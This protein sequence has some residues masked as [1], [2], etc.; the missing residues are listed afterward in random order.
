MPSC[1]GWTGTFPS[2]DEQDAEI[3]TKNLQIVVEPGVI[4]ADL[5]EELKNIIFFPPDPS[6][7]VESTLG[8]N[9][10]ENAGYT[11][12]V[13]YGVMTIISLALKLFCRMER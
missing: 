13:K 1:S 8:G 11:R 10:A 7:T 12:A 9:V 6:S 5:Q 3:D 4:A 2:P